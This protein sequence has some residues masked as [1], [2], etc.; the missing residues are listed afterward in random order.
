MGCAT[1][2]GCWAPGRQPT[3]SV[4]NGWCEVLP[5]SGAV[6]VSGSMVLRRSSVLPP[7]VMHVKPVG[8][9][10]PDYGARHVSALVLI[11][12]PGR[13]TSHQSR[14]GGHGPG[15]DADG[16][17]G[18]GLVGGRQ[19][20]ARHGG[21]DRACAKPP[22]TGTCSGSTRSTRSRGRRTWCGWC[23]RS[24]SSGEGGAAGVSGRRRQRRDYA[25]ASRCRR[26]RTEGSLRL[27]RRRRRDDRRGNGVIQVITHVIRPVGL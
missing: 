17:A 23:C 10:Q 4:S 18:G 9:P 11:V 12:E 20:P 5:A 26:S 2:T 16:D 24:P 22:S 1:G 14:S 3:R 27:P 15:T 6:A 7:F 19:E 21:C 8:L 13:Q 25:G